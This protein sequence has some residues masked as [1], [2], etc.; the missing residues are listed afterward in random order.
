MIIGYL[1]HTRTAVLYSPKMSK[2]YL[3]LFA[4]DDCLCITTGENFESYNLEISGD[5]QPPCHS[6]RGRRG[7]LSKRDNSIRKSNFL[8]F[9][10]FLKSSFQQLLD[11][12]TF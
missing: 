4:Y 5:V 6:E 9:D 1:M 3:S 11:L 12:K 7:K 8:T 10:C 2:Y